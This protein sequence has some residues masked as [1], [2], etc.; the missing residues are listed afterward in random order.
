LSSKSKE[1]YKRKVYIAWDDNGMNSSNES[2]IEEA[3]LCFL[4]NYEEDEVNSLKLEYEL[5]IVCE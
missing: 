3:N 1:I 5:L 4:E 2:E